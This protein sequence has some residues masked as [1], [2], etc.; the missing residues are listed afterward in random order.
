MDC[1]YLLQCPFYNNLMPDMLEFLSLDKAR[2]CVDDLSSCARYQ[3]SKT[4]GREKL[5]MDLYP[6]QIERVAEILGIRH[7]ES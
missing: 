2:Y 7:F 5:P 3:V 6:R 4:V 1:T